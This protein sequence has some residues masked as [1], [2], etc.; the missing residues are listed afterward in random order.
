MAHSVSLSR[1]QVLASAGV[2][3]AA[4]GLGVG[5]ALTSAAS[6]APAAPSAGAA[7]ASAALR[8]S[9]FKAL[10]GKNFRFAGA[11]TAPVTLRLQAVDGLGSKAARERAFA[12]RFTGP[13]ARRQGG[14]VGLLEGDGVAAHLLVVP[15]GRA[16]PHGQDWVATVQSGGSHD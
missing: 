12:L 4:A 1:R 15:S 6:A 14:E 7:G 16:M 9:A 3:G 13:V 10:V 5:P 2:L 11:G 8:A